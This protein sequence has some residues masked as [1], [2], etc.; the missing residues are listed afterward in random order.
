[1]RGDADFMVYVG[2]R[3]PT[4]VREA[5][6]LGCPP[7]RAAEAVVD[8]LSRCRGSWGRAS[9]EEGVD[10]LVGDELAAACARRP[11]NATSAEE[12][13]A[14]AEELVILSP[15][16]LEELR[17]QERARQTRTAKL[18]LG[19]L[20]PLLLVAAGLTWW[21]TRDAGGDDEPPELKAASVTMAENPAPGVT[22][23]ANGQLHLEHVVLAVEGLRDMTRL[24]SGSVV[25]GDDE[26][27]VVYVAD[28]GDRRVLGHKDPDVPVAATDEN[29]WAAWVDLSEERP[30]LVVY[31]AAGGDLIG[32][33]PVDTGARVV[34]VDGDSVY[35]VDSEGAHA[36]LPTGD[37]VIPVTPANLIDVRSRTRA[38]QVSADTTQVVQSYFDVQ[39]YLPGRGV[40]LSPDGNFVITNIG[41]GGDVDLAVYDT[42]SGAEL[43]KG[44]A[45]TDV[46]LAA[47]AGEGATVAY[48]VAQGG[49]DSGRELQLRTCDLRTSMCRIVARIPGGDSTPVLAR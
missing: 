14:Q 11:S 5:V 10:S 43:V 47:A 9:R 22:W 34:A 31:Q 18:S 39:F 48:V 16:S 45:I 36:L 38:F 20:V 12:R 25:Y 8:A 37:E 6:L 41:E 29:G 49:L 23:W 28:D 21:T 3:W 7:E 42:R 19:L 35:F 4:L 46:A 44:L 13:R 24:T 15:P 32:T 26:G 27:R 40:S 2:A 17:A 33:I 30:R 1:M